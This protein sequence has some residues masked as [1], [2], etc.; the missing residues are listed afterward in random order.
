MVEKVISYG[1]L[2]TILTR[3]YLGCSSSP[4]FTNDTSTDTI[5]KIPLTSSVGGITIIKLNLLH[6][7]SYPVQLL[8]LLEMVVVYLP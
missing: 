5:R 7:E 4:L 2:E 8:L 6:Q 1:I 3:V